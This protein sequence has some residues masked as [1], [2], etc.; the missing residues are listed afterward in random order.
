MNSVSPPLPR[1][2]RIAGMAAAVVLAIICTTARSWLESSMALHMLLQM[3]LLIAAGIC[4]QV[5]LPERACP[6]ALLQQ[7]RQC[8]QHGV[9]SLLAILLIA[10]YWMIP[11]SVEQA[12]TSLQFDVLKF[13]ALF[14]AG[15]L[16][17]GGLRRSNLIIQIFL[18]GN[19]CGM[20]AIIAML[21]QDTPQRLCNSY[22]L[23]DQSVT[24]D[25]LLCFSLLIPMAWLV[26]QA[27][28]NT[29]TLSS[30]TRYDPNHDPSH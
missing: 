20:M 27:F 4:L 2:F 18:I 24:G 1:R 25:G 10:T 28:N 9:C 19:L 21:F 22:L 13:V 3:P 8:D 5:A 12:V 15:M 7:W 23:D 30:E 11:I 26:A 6:S 17:P 16:L 14:I 29:K